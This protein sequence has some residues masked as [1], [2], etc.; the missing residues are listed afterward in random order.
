M[1]ATRFGGA[2]SAQGSSRANII[3]SRFSHNTGMK[4]GAVY[5]KEA[6]LEANSSQFNDNQA[7]ETGGRVSCDGRG[8][9]QDAGV[10]YLVRIVGVK[11]YD[12]ELTRNQVA[13]LPKWSA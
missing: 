13:V 5:I 9:D 1:Q 8:Y 12:A 6:S 4:G 10:F 7:T 11:V 3:S 2:L